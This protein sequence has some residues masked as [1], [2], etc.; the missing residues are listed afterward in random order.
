MSF[1]CCCQDAEWE[2]EEEVQD[3]DQDQ[4]IDNEEYF[5][6]P[7]I[8]KKLGEQGTVGCIIVDCHEEIQLFWS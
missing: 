8:R 1:V 6:D 5:D 3:D 4:G 2:H 7:K